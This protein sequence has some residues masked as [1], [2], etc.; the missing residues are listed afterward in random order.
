MAPRKT[1]F[2]KLYE[3]GAE[4]GHVSARERDAVDWY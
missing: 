3:A 4:A 2:E 1:T